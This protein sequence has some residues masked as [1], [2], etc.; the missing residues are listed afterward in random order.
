VR[1]RQ[2]TSWVAAHIEGWTMSQHIPNMYP[3]AGD[4]RDGS[5][6]EFFFYVRD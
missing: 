5:L 1:H 2:F 3:S 6:A 4:Y